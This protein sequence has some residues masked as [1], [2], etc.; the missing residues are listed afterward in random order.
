MDPT[1]LQTNIEK[2][3]KEKYPGANI[4][5]SLAKTYPPIECMEVYYCGEQ[6]AYSASNDLTQLIRVAEKATIKYYETHGLPPFEKSDVVDYKFELARRQWSESYPTIEVDMIPTES[7][8]LTYQIFIKDKNTRTLIASPANISIDKVIAEADE[9]I[10]KHIAAKAASV[11]L[12]M[13]QKTHDIIVEHTK[14]R[15]A[16]SYPGIAM[17]IFKLESMADP[18]E[19]RIMGNDGPTK[20]TSKDGSDVNKI[21]LAAEM[22]VRKYWDA[23]KTATVSSSSYRG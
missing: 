23:K 6:I 1:V 18:P 16:T 10:K 11:P 4:R 21:I 13:D 15:W 9:R 3:W 22:D 12:T 14:I 20:V 8:P 17:T 5:W 19:Y 2:Q 7:I